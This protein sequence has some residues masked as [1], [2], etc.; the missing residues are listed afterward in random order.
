MSV[1]ILSD[2]HI[3]H[4]NM[5]E[6]PFENIEPSADILL[7]VGDTCSIY[8]FDCLFNY[9]STISPF[10]RE[11]LFISGNHEYYTVRG[12]EGV[13]IEYLKDKLYF[14]EEKINNLTILDKKYIEI[15]DYVIAGCT[16][17]SYFSDGE[18]P[19]YMRVHGFN[20]QVY[21]NLHQEDVKFI[22]NTIHYCKN[23]NKKLILATHY[24]PT[25][26]FNE[27]PCY[28]NN[29][30]SLYGSDL[31]YL[32]NGRN[33][34]T[35][36]FGHNHGIIQKNINTLI[37]GTHVVTNQKGRGKSAMLDYSKNKTLSF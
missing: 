25:K 37:R 24:P 11:V 21:N 20:K 16:L 27:N 26:K 32:I 23:N 17:W 33:V 14:M 6:S 29:Y 28:K 36:I 7:I 8:N 1:Q 30:M 18:F 13:D 10:F 12:I 4:K 15:G 31:D 5:F 35:W 34:H 22:K 9:V 19:K 3:D 2:L